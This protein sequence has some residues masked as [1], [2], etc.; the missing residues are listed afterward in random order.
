MTTKIPSKPI[1]RKQLHRLYLAF[2]LQYAIE[3]DFT[4]IYFA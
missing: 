1:N 4:T 3:I 2:T